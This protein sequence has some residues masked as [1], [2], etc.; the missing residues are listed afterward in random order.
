MKLPLRLLICSWANGIGGGAARM[1]SYYL[2]FFD[3]E[4]IEATLV[5][6]VPD[7][8]QYSYSF[9]K[10]KVIT[11][12]EANTFSHLVALFKSADIV[13]FQG[14][15]DPLVCEAAKMA[16][17]PLL[18]EV[19]HN[20]EEGGAFDQIDFSI[21]VSTAVSNAQKAY[22]KNY[23]ILNGID[24]EEFY[25]TSHRKKTDANKDK[26][27]L[28]QVANRSK[29]GIHL[30]EIAPILLER[31]SNLEFWI[32]GREQNLVST[33][34]SIK[35]LGVVD[36][37]QDLYHAADFNVLFSRSEPFGL[38]VIEGMACGAIPV[39]SGS[40]GF[41]DIVTHEKDG[42]ILEENTPEYATRLLDSIIVCM[43][44][45][46][47]TFSRMR[48][49]GRI[50]VENTFSAASCVRQYQDLYLQEF[51]IK[52]RACS[53]ITDE[54]RPENIPGNALIGEAVYHFQ[55]QNFPSVFDTLKRIIK[56]KNSINHP[57]CIEVACD[58]AQCSYLHGEYTLATN[59]FLFLIEACP[60][61]DAII[62]SW[63]TL[64]CN[65]SIKTDEA[66]LLKEKVLS[67]S[68]IKKDQVLCCAEI[69]LR[70]NDFKNALE[71][72]SEAKEKTTSNSNLSETFSAMYEKMA[73]SLPVKNVR[74]Y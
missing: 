58:L 12:P 67:Q 51:S 42:F 8:S 49:E 60:D 68:E 27:I 21:C 41:L 65:H 53:S 2:N 18:T 5:R 62:N 70:A 14:G 37:I 52:S 36:S 32:V 63:I 57:L 25:F 33:N 61:P 20:I 22:H 28:L 38:A 1:E 54:I 7:T 24:L 6:L 17:V 44:N 40:G 13:Q 3:P 10:A 43:K 71:T 11:L 46:E 29:L 31:H 56:H 74:K 47:D 23:I 9:D 15:F 59:L 26:I 73:Q 64:A 66:V 16:E 39:V 45:S 34:E 19:L 48:I 30:D 55:A 35:Y 50:K 72:L 4:Y 69:F